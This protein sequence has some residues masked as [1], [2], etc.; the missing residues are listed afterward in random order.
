MKEILLIIEHYNDYGDYLYSKQENKFCSDTETVHVFNNSYTLE[1]DDVEYP[2]TL[3]LSTRVKLGCSDLLTKTI[4]NQ[5]VSQHEY[6]DK[7]R[8]RI[9]LV[10]KCNEITLELC[11]KFELSCDQRLELLNEYGLNCEL[12]KNCKIEETKLL[13]EIIEIEYSESIKTY[14]IIL[15]RGVV[16]RVRSLSGQ[17]MGF[18]SVY[19][20]YVDNKNDDAVT[21]NIEHQICKKII[22]KVKK[23][24]DYKLM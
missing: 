2:K 6:E 5:K 10:E 24:K 19:W 8:E 3:I 23:I 18:Y 15:D 1:C 17:H 13:N 16:T 22:N 4:E 11:D 7:I 21:T 12:I 9:K 20:I 14:R